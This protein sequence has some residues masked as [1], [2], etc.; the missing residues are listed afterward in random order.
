MATTE[1][2][3]QEVLLLSR[4]LWRGPTKHPEPALEGMVPDIQRQITNLTSWTGNIHRDVIQNG[5]LLKA[6]NEETLGRIE[7]QIRAVNEETLGR[8]ES[9]IKEVRQFLSAI[10]EETLGRIETK[11]DGLK[12]DMEQESARLHAHLGEIEKAIEGL[13]H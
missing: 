7:S 1:Q 4:Y 13:P 11:L 10:N 2:V 9:Q 3:L 8:I 12:A 5:S 6:V